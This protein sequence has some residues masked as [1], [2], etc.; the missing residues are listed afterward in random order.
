MTPTP[1]YNPRLHC[2]HAIVGALKNYRKNTNANIIRLGLMFITSPRVNGISYSA[3]IFNT[4][5]IFDI[6]VKI[7]NIIVGSAY[8]WGTRGWIK[9]IR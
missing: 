8:L 1:P 2:F 9:K 5:V 7:T 6:N 4:T 3:G